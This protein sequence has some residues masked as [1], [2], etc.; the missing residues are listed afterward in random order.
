[1]L[2]L[3]K[4]PSWIFVINILKKY[5]SDTAIRTMGCADMDALPSTFELLLWNMQ[6]CRGNAWRKDFLNLIHDRHL[7]LLQEASLSA[8]NLEIFDQHEQYFWAMARSFTHLRRQSENG[9]KTGCRAEPI[10]THYFA[11]PNF[12]PLVQTHKML[13]RTSYAI[14]G[15]DETL[16]VFNLHAL[17]FSRLDSYKK[18]LIQVLTVAV[19]HKGPM[20]LAGDFNTWSNNRFAYLQQLIEELG[21]TEA[22]ITRKS[23]ARHFYR[24][25]DHLFY[26]G[27]H[28]NMAE[29]VDSVDSSDHL[30]IVAQLSTI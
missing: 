21:L 23:K 24:H 29:I 15:R 3:K 18:H 26:R 5:Q 12:E 30:P 4:S 9:V 16:M 14:E 17:N 20:I 6:K 13:L 10:E 19:E 1:M 11:S 2:E 8:V 22:E 7:V 25:L 28:L 27:L